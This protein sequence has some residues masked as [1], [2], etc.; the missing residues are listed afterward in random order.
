MAAAGAAH[1][2]REG[3]AETIRGWDQ[4]LRALL[5]ADPETALERGSSADGTG[6]DGGSANPVTRRWPRC[7]PAQGS[8]SARDR[9]RYSA[10]GRMDTATA[11]RA[12]ISGI[13]FGALLWTVIGLGTAIRLSRP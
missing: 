1:D 2:V 13:S 5:A 7:H 9:R 12:A 8:E 10:R 3:G 6:A 11:P 4:L